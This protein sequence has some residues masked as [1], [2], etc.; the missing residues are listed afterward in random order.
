MAA[1]DNITNHIYKIYR[2][3][4]WQGITYS[5]YF[6][7]HA[8]MQNE[9]YDNKDVNNICSQIEKMYD[10]FLNPTDKSAKNTMQKF[11]EQ[12]NKQFLEEK[13]Y[14]QRITAEQVLIPYS[15]KEA[16]DEARKR[17]DAKIIELKDKVIKPIKYEINQKQTSVRLD[18]LRNK[19]EQI[20]KD[21]KNLQS[22]F[23]NDDEIQKM[24]N[25]ELQNVN[26]S[27][28]E[29]KRISKLAGMKG[30][31]LAT[32]DDTIIKTKSGSGKITQADFESLKEIME[33][34][35]AYTDFLTTN[36]ETL[37]VLNGYVGELFAKTIAELN[38]AGSLDKAEEEME[39]AVA[40]SIN[41]MVGEG[42]QG[43]IQA[44][45]VPL[46]NTI[47]MKDAS[48]DVTDNSQLL[49]TRKHTNKIDV[50]FKWK[51][52]DANTLPIKASIKNYKGIS[53]LTLLDK[54]P[55]STV[56]DYMGKEQRY[57]MINMLTNFSEPTIAK[58]Q[59]AARKSL[60]L[61]ILAYALAGYVDSNDDDKG[62][63]NYFIVFDNSKNKTHCM[64]IPTAL[65]ELANRAI[66]NGVE[67]FN[68][69]IGNLIRSY[70][71][72]LS[73]HGDFENYYINPLV[74]Y[75]EERQGLDYKEERQAQRLNKIDEEFARQKLHVQ[76]SL[77]INN[78]TK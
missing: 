40:N 62:Y 7:Q 3:E 75:K 52:N 71:I 72:E 19:L 55:L 12:V 44:T 53:S 66:E 24:L 6:Q 38:A 45:F 8:M 28:K 18:I 29:V 32:V 73:N 21:L 63:A 46:K 27:L 59:L 13:K 58:A 70:K 30:R 5:D 54:S 50:S 31:V 48:I 77:L 22:S 2:A 1:I 47:Q 14:S 34:V 35:N 61:L 49:I 36:A 23:K 11:A 20:Q 67:V 4:A 56:F 69:D 43:K 78:I 33:N 25:N 65:R 74:L 17:L 57:V 41:Y 15:G 76:I 39:N 51:L 68:K 16:S 64:H 42:G 9:I 26:S 10:S 60:K 37:A